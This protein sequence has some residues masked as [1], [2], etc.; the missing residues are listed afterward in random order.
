MS[1]IEIFL[2]VVI[3]LE[4]ICGFILYFS[5]IKLSKVNKALKNSI[6]IQDTY[7]KELEAKQR[8][9]KRYYNKNKKQA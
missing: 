4:A 1:N 3:G 9:K 2:T 6:L 8:P 7:I 5:T